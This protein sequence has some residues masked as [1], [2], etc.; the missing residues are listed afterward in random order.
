LLPEQNSSTFARGLDMLS[1]EDE[2]FFYGA[3]DMKII[4]NLS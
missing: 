1:Q 2:E 4:K 3:G